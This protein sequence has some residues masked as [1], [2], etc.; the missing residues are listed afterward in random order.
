[1]KIKITVRHALLGLTAAAALICAI[2]NGASADSKAFATFKKGAPP[3][4]SPPDEEMVSRLIVK[5]RARRSDKLVAALK[6][7]DTRGLNKSTHVSMAIMRPM[8]GDAHVVK[9][10]QPVRLSE[11]RVIAARLMHDGDV[12]LAEPDRMLHVATTLTPRDPGYSSQW[13]Y[14]APAGVN[15]GGANLPDAWFITVGDPSVTVAVLDSGYRQHADLAP[16][17]PGYDFITRTDVSNDN[18]GRDADAS[19]PG[20]GVA[21]NE[22]GAGTS[23]SSSSWHGTH[24]AGTIAALM[25]NTGPAGQHGAG[26]APRVK[27]LPVRVIGKCGGF[28]SDIV[29]GMRWAAG[30]PFAGS[31]P[32]NANPAQILNM[33]LSGKGACSNTFQDAVSDIVARGKVI[34]V[35]AGNS[36]SVAVGQPANCMGVIA[37]TAHAIDGD[38]ASYANI[39]THTAI[40]APGG[41]CGSFSAGCTAFASANGPGVY[42]LSNSGTATPVA[43]SYSVKIGTSMAAPHVS[44][45]V[46]LML[47]K[48]PSLTPAQIKS[49]LQSSSRPHPDG[50]I[51]TDS[52]YIGLCGEGLL[53]ALSALNKTLDLAPIVSLTN[54]YQVVA[55]NAAVSLSSTDTA[56]RQIASYE[57]V[58]QAGAAVGAIAGAA[59]SNAIFTAPMTGTYSF[60][61]TVTDSAGKIGTATATVRVNSAPVLIA[62]A[63]QAVM[64]GETLSFTV[65]ATDADG[66][67]PV[68]RMEP[69]PSGDATLDPAT[70]VFNWPNAAP[71]GTYTLTYYASDSFDSTQGNVTITVV[72]RPSSGGGSLDDK[73]L[74]ALALL[75]A[76]MRMHRA[77]KRSGK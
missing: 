5:H 37:V 28:T 38:N 68:F 60:K 39:G 9:L 26:V 61:H 44:G 16:V 11:A 48:N 69:L 70:G 4:A 2:A 54:A 27:L 23:D 17:L 59:T 77:F 64:A 6:A 62:V 58:Q 20:D 35:A 19:D 31:P 32:A 50:T 29:D 63:D 3:V 40:S 42:S 71:S 10:N 34:V 66:D 33:S 75:A 15:K 52:H 45:V 18:G 51:C 14:F 72:A 76:C 57:W 12:E 7:F 46:A 36:G 1:M 13:H 25:D 22:C 73:S 74:F 41:G 56:P 21:K 24:V 67:T 30:I 47:S 55:P 8:S 43:D 49:Y 53:D 65:G